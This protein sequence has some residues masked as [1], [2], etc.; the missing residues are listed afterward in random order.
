MREARLFHLSFS[1][2]NT[3]DPHDMMTVVRGVAL[4][5]P[6]SHASLLAYT[7]FLVDVPALSAGRGGRRCQSWTSRN[8]PT[9]ENAP[10][11]YI[12]QTK[13]SALIPDACVFGSGF[14]RVEVGSNP[15][16]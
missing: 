2:M 3:A 13:R 7:M 6:R 9:I 5:P 15:L 11:Q 1:N 4:N 10:L 16:A 14:I 8:A 12:K